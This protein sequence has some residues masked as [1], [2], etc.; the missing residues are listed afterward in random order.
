MATSIRQSPTA[1]AAG[2][3]LGLLGWIGLV[4]GLTWPLA[5]SPETFLSNRGSDALYTIWALAWE[6]HALLTDPRHLLDANIYHPALHALLY[7][8]TAL[9]A[10]VLFGPAFVLTGDPVAAGNVLFIGGTALTAWTT[11]LVTRRWTGSSAAGIVAGCAYL[12]VPWVLWEW[13]PEAPH[14]AALF[15]LPLIFELVS[16]A[17]LRLRDTVWLSLLVAL[18][19]S[20]EPVYIAPAIFVPLGLIAVSRICRLRTRPNGLALTGAI[21][22]AFLLLLPLLLAYAEIARANPHLELQSMWA[23]KPGVPEQ[24]SYILNLPWGL[25]GWWRARITAWGAS[26]MAL[27]PAAFA[28]ILS[29]GASFLARRRQAFPTT[30]AW[31]HAF[32]WATAGVLLALPAVA[33]WYDTRITL[34]FAW[35]YQHLPSL[36]VV[37]APMRLGVVALIGLSLATGLAFAELGD[38]LREQLGSSTTKVP[39]SFATALALGAALLAQA[40]TGV[41]YP[42]EFKTIARPSSYPVATRPDV[43]PFSAEL[44]GGNGPLLEL[45]SAVFAF[46]YNV[47]EAQTMFRSIGHWRP[48]I[49]GYSS[50]WP[51]TYPEAMT[52][53]ARLP[54]DAS[55]VAALQQLTGVELILV[56]LDQLP[57]PRRD[58]WRVRADASAS[59]SLELV[60]RDD[61]ALLFRVRSSP[62]LALSVQH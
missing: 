23:E 40:W 42:P 4:S 34:P 2:T 45:G 61:Q 24:R 37:R 47:P 13:V 56:R 1:K 49:N 60:A 31:R 17:S 33:Y 30:A 43:G 28:L 20:V 6:S 8:P 35:L 59:G 21:V 57:V 15:C 7:G 36:R 5:S 9:G 58:A 38:R 14:Y 50:Y 52:L 29:G 18:Q 26:P 41:G 54:D 44:R 39:W 11:A 10:L 48:L 16:R 51:T 62:Q 55:A 12:S 25:F 3:L 27:P 32:I 46:P 19:G 22:G 53:A